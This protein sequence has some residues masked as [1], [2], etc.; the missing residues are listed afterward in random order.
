MIKLE[1]NSSTKIIDIAINGS[2]ANDG[3]LRTA[4]II[5][6]LTNRRADIDDILPEDT[7][8]KNSIIPEDRQGWVGDALP[9]VAGDLIGSRLWLLSRG[10]Q[11]EETRQKAIEYAKEALQWLIDDGHALDMRV[12]AEWVQSEL[13]HLLV[14]LETSS[15]DFEVVVSKNIGAN[16]GGAAYVV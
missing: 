13:L 11:T 6:L 5:S 7:G 9:E 10:K 12:T 2:I 15:G 14:Q 16:I 3:D 1:P 4:V 8:D